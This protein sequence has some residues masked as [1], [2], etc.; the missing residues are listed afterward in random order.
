MKRKDK[1][2]NLRL[3]EELYD[4]VRERVNLSGLKRIQFVGKHEVLASCSNL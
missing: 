4:A 3:P 1:S 2:I